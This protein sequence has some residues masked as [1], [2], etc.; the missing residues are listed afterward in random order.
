[1][2]DSNAATDKGGPWK[3]AGKNN[4]TA[5]TGTVNDTIAMADST[6]TVTFETAAYVYRGTA[7]TATAQTTGSGSLATPA[8]VYSG[9]CTNAGS[10]NGCTATATYAGDSN[11]KGSSDTKSI[12]IAKASSTV[13]LDC[14]AG[15]TYMYTGS[16]Q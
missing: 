5:G 11:H 3:L 8:V 16:P 2:A 6:T 12:T 15:G 13:T 9:D 1:F 7:F 10:T 4:Y 14:T